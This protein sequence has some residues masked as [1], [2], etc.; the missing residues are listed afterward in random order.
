MNAETRATM[1]IASAPRTMLKKRLMW[2]V[3]SFMQDQHT[4]KGAGLSFLA[5]DLLRV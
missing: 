1:S 5:L 3:F 4:G 2:R